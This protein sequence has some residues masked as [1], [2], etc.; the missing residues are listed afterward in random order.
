MDLTL[1]TLDLMDKKYFQ[2]IS[3]AKLH[4]AEKILN[5]NINI[6]KNITR[7]KKNSLK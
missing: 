6:L 4:I 3:A 1:N 5:Q 7:Q 2:D